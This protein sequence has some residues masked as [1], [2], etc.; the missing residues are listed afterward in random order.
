M[1]S[2]RTLTLPWMS[3]LNQ[4]KKKVVSAKHEYR[5]LKELFRMGTVQSLALTLY[6]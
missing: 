1:T 3:G 5:Q 6:L 4:I 2:Q